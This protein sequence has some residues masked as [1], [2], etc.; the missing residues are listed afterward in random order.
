[1]GGT[2]NGWISWDFWWKIPSFEIGD[3][4]GYPYDE[5]ETPI[6][7]YHHWIIIQHLTRCPSRR[8]K[9][10]IASPTSTWLNLSKAS[11]ALVLPESLTEM[12]EARGCLCWD[13]YDKWIFK[14]QN[15][16]FFISRTI[17]RFRDTKHK[18][19]TSHI[20]SC[21]GV[22]VLSLARTIAQNPPSKYSNL[23]SL[24]CR[25]EKKK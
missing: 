13:K 14:F 12:W 5:T 11:A 2:Q 20:R 19:K 25:A 8:L 24:R 22:Q 21:S 10:G 6:Y 15:L 4:W 7:Q 18:H 16:L 9:D 23:R 17:L 1:M 3:D